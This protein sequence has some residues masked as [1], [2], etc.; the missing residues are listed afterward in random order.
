MNRAFIL[1]VAFGVV[2]HVGAADLF[3]DD[4]SSSTN[5]VKA[6]GDV[7]TS[8]SN[9]QFV[10]QNTGSNWAFF[11]HDAS[12]S[13]FTYSVKLNALTPHSVQSVVRPVP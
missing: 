6:Y 11:K 9:G 10:V 1:A 5:W 12:Y 7:S 3:E 2:G 13:T 4:F 8:V